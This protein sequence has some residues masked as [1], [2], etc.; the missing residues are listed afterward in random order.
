MAKRRHGSLVKSTK[1]ETFLY[2]D[3]ASFLRSTSYN[4]QLSC[5]P[6]SAHLMSYCCNCIDESVYWPLAL[7]AGTKLWFCVRSLLES[8]V[9]IPPGF[10][11]FLVSVVCCRVAASAT[12]WS[13][14]QRSRTEFGVSE[15]SRNLISEEAW[16]HYSCR[17]KKVGFLTTLE[18]GYVS[19]MWSLLGRSCWAC[20]WTYNRVTVLR[21]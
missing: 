13:L 12:C 15:W 11:M 21:P 4:Q 1:R 7:V 17:A 6:F 18:L 10:W 8:W 9:R 5:S 16:A 20:R 14:V 19:R 2:P 3:V